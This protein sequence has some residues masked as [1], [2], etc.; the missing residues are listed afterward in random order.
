[1]IFR[2]SISNSHGTRIVLAVI[3]TT[4]LAACGGSDTDDTAGTAPAPSAGDSSAGAGDTA[5]ALSGTITFNGPR[6]ERAVLLT[7]SDPK[8]T[9]MHVDD[10]LLS[11]RELVSA[12]GGIKNVFLYIKGPPEGDYPVPAQQAVLDQIGCRYIPHVV[13]V[14]VG[15]EIS[16]RN[17]DPMLH[18][19]RSFAREN[20]PFNNSQPAGAAP[21]IKKFDKMELAIRMKC[22]IHPWMTAFIFALDHPFFATADEDGAYAIHGLPPGEYTLVAWHEKYGEQEATVTISEGEGA[23]A[24]FVFEPAD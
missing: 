5:A 2:G 6:P 9:A 8:C 13:G 12:D 10:P 15:Q 11:D 16:V 17:S 23:V 20:R 1:M 24:D 19:V 18:N 21:R 22:D 3:C 14:Q 7:D 4:A